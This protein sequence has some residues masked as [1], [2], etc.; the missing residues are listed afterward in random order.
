MAQVVAL[1]LDLAESGHVSGNDIHT[2]VINA[3][4]T[5]V[6]HQDNVDGR[7]AWTCTCPA[8]QHRPYRIG[9]TAYCK[10]TLARAIAARAGLVKED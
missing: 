6:Y 7:G 9:P 5:V 3:E 1:A 10:H 8:Y 2:Q 4:R